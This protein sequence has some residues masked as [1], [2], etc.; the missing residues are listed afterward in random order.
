M[1]LRKKGVII[2]L[3]CLALVVSEDLLRKPVLG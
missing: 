3:H 1:L 2:K